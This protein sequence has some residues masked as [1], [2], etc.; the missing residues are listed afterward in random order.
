MDENKKGD[1]MEDTYVVTKDGIN[2]KNSC[3][4]E[5]VVREI[6]SKEA[7]EEYLVK[8]IQKQLQDF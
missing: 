5:D 1:C 6:S 3:C 4:V 8:T 7:L 2:K